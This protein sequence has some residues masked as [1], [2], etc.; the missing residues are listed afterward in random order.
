MKY[1]SISLYLLLITFCSSFT[2][3]AKNKPNVF[4]FS[5]E[6]YHAA[7]KNWAIS[8]DDR[9][10]MYFANDVGLVEFDG[11][12]WRLYTLP[13]S[14]IMRSVYAFSH[15]TI[16][17]G[18]Y[19]EF[20]RWDRDLSGHLVYTS[21]SSQLG[22]QIFNND[23]F[24]K[25]WNSGKC[26]YFQSFKGIYCYSDN[27]VRPFSNQSKNLL[28]LYGVRG[29]YYVQEVLGGLY[30]IDDGQYHKIEGSEIFANKEVRV[31]LPYGKDKM[32]IGTSSNGFYI[33]DGT[34][35]SEWK[36]NLSAIMRRDELNCG[37]LSSQGT[38]F[39]GTILN[40][41]YEVDPDGKILNHISSQNMLQNN[42]VLSVFEDNSGNI[43]AGMD[44]GLSY[45]YY[46]PQMS[47]YTDPTG[48]I[49]A[50]YDAQ[51][52][53]NKLFI[54]TNQGV[55]FIPVSD[56]SAPN[57][58]SL[59]RL[60]NGTQGQSWNLNIVDG[61]LYC[62]HNRGLKQIE[63]GSLSV[64]NVFDRTGAYHVK[65][66][67][68]RGHNVLLISSYLG[69]FIMDKATGKLNYL[70]QVPSSI[71]NIEIDH[72]GN[73]WL[74]HP[75][76]GICMGQINDELDRFVNFSFHG[77]NVGDALPYKMKIFKVGG[78]VL[79]LGNDKFYTYD[80]IANEIIPN[81]HLNECFNNISDIRNI[82]YIANNDYWAI[83]G[84]ALYRFTYNGYKASISENYKL[85]SN[86]SY[87]NFYENVSVV[88]DSLSFVCLDNGFLI[89]NKNSAEYNL[90][91][92]VQDS[93]II[94]SMVAGNDTGK[95]INID[96]S[97]DVEIPY[98]YNYI[99]VSF[100]SS[101]TF[102]SDL[103][104]QYMLEGVNSNW[105]TAR[106]IN[107]L[108]YS[109]LPQ[110]DYTL[111]IRS[112][113][114]FGGYSEPVSLKFSINSP[115][116]LTYWAYL[117]YIILAVSILYII[118]MFI[119]RR[120]RNLHLKKIRS[121][122]SHRLRLINQRL[123][124]EIEKK[125]AELFTQT[126]FI[127]QKNDLIIKLKDIVEDFYQKNANKALTPLYQKVR[128][129]LENNLDAEDDWKTFLLKFE[130]KHRDFFKKLK[131]M[132]PQ[133]TNNDLR[134]CACL[135]LNL[136]TKE[137]ASLMNLS[138]RTIENNRYRLRKKLDIKPTESLAD[139]FINFE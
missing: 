131:I 130:E 60:I 84:R 30:K 35:F 136:D 16:Y 91:K 75:Y 73:L 52:W 22:N 59:I 109:R 14:V 19:E 12:E 58:L 126:S 87:V 55:F 113:N 114:D 120:Y 24:W 53:D 39:F 71:L 25:I 95:L 139:F 72:L 97:K 98:D 49:G 96:L 105:S 68:V 44:R 121:R 34:N 61:K 122:E 45:I 63:A 123:Q 37:I 88:N 83:T 28:F 31:V 65:D 67:V 21:L 41:L 108:T 89:Y 2:I 50:V 103:S 43:W 56:L 111:K 127:I 42:T 107:T 74:E 47:C 118:W 135:K 106:K 64:R 119:L 6:D 38:Y 20:G 102:T 110:G 17:T 100:S 48:V 62:C 32:L 66:A 90:K 115:W 33:Y 134:L 10:F 69:L 54:A 92:E 36:D 93:P 112:V 128:I 129:L 3:K 85:S 27:A 40:G 15:N 29:Q 26:I 78:R 81:E 94:E 79:F 133:L 125:N 138:V 8:Q 11:I 80:D 76:K 124:G 7:N 116:Y 5:K 132:H 82:I 1:F 99:T 104:F 18:G 46:L 4:N 51:I 77:G 137:I 13:N 70:D 57:P 23:E 9:G 86:L 117:I 101:K